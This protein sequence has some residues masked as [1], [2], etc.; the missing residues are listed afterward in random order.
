MSTSVVVEK[1]HR[2]DPCTAGWGTSYGPDR[3]RSNQPWMRDFRRL[4]MEQDWNYYRKKLKQGRYHRL[5]NERKIAMGKRHIPHLCPSGD[6]FRRHIRDRYDQPLQSE[7]MLLSDTQWLH[8]DKSLGHHHH[9]VVKCRS[10]TQHPAGSGP[11]ACH[12]ILNPPDSST[13]PIVLLGMCW[14]RQEEVLHVVHDSHISLA[15]TRTA[16]I[17]K[18]H[19]LRW[20]HVICEEGQLIIRVVTWRASETVFTISS[21]THDAL[22]R[23]NQASTQS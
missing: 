15:L 5:H 13:N 10:N 21:R 20:M 4:N 14:G 2:L 11:W 3:L 23:W 12:S 17:I 9:P 1:R 22:L 6:C 18:V 8:C 19:L 16:Q 7:V